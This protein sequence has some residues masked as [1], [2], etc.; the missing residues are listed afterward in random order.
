VEN[1]ARLLR[2]VVEA[3]C[4]V[5]GP[6]RVGVRLSPLGTSNDMGDE[7]PEATFGYIAER[8]ND[9][10]LAYLH[11]INPA[12]EAFDKSLEPDPR[13]LWIMELMREQYRG[14][15]MVAGGFEQKT[16]EAW[17]KQGKADLVAFGRK[18]LANPDLPE[19]FRQQAVLNA[20]DPSTFYGG[21]YK[22][23]TDYPSLAQERGEQPTPCIDE[24]WR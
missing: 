18:F 19:R 2:E 13:A 1:R 20:P 23:Y 15:L 10:Q 8:L 9:Y 22:G 3:V 21:G 6:D 16:A 11:V 4:E 24:R 5:W 17:L 7:D 12:T 14:T